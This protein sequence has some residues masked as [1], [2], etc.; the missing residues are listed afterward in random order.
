MKLFNSWS[1][2]MAAIDAAIDDAMTLAHALARGQTEPG[3]IEQ[4]LSKN[5]EDTYES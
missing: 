5:G 1:R 3:D 2:D 4:G